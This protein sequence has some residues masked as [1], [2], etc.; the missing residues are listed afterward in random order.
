M[1]LQAQRNTCGQPRHLILTR[2]Q[3]ES[4]DITGPC[5]VV[6]ELANS[7]V[8]VGIYAAETVKILR[9]EIMRPPEFPQEPAAA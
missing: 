5:R 6:I 8:R 4:I 1:S 3:G 2:D 9:T 7:P